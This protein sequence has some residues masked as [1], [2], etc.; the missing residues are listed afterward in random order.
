MK[1]A[2]SSMDGSGGV[3]N[4][5]GIEKSAR[6]PR[7]DKACCR[8]FRQDLAGFASS[9]STVPDAVSINEDVKSTSENAEVEETLVA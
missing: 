9:P 6:E 7:H 8:C 3:R 4:G 2:A 1:G 5:S